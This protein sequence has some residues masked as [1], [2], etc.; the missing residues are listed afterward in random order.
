M[1]SVLEFKL[2]IDYREERRLQKKLRWWWIDCFH[3]RCSTK[4]NRNHA[5]IKR[6]RQ[7]NQ[8]WNKKEEEIIKESINNGSYHYMYWFIC[9]KLR[10]FYIGW[11]IKFCKIK[12]EKEIKIKIKRS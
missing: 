4:E 12:Q 10:A 9:L 3:N 7:E 11:W 8:I 5:G 2:K 6:S 1:S